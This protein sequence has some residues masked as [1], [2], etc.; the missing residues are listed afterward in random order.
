[1][2]RILK[3]ENNGYKAYSKSESDIAR[4]D[5]ALVK[6]DSLVIVIAGQ[7]VTTSHNPLKAV[8]C[9]NMAK[10]TWSG[11]LP[12][13][14]QARGSPSACSLGAYIFVFCGWAGG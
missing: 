3:V 8:S 6:V 11:E 13:L 14:K 2:C 9:F 4:F 1:M 10:N 7:D 12:P 5:P